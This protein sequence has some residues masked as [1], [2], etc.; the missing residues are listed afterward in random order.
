MGFYIS[1]LFV[2]AWDPHV[3]KPR[4]G[5]FVYESKKA[6]MYSYSTIWFEHVIAYIY[7][8]ICYFKVVLSLFN[9]YLGTL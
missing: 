7:Y 6:Q 4:P 1:A 3:Y 8:L 9:I 2:S 5:G